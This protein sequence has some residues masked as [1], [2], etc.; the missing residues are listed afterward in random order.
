MNGQFGLAVADPLPT[1]ALS[2]DWVIPLSL[3]E[4]ARA[5]PGCVRWA[6]RGSLRGFFYGLLFDR[7]ALAKSIDRNLTDCSNAELV[8]RT[9]ERWGETALSRLRGSFVMFIVDPARGKA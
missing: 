3:D 6:E 5:L 9:Y 7:E 2:D 1:K 8:L 4:P